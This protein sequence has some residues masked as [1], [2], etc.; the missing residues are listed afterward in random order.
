MTIVMPRKIS[1]PA[2]VTMNDGTRTNAIQ[3]PC[4]APTS[5]PNARQTATVS[6][7]DMPFVT[8][9]VA[10]IAPTTA[11]TEPTERSMSPVRMHGSMPMARMRM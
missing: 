5:R 10:E 9:I 7:T 4:H 3:K 2:S 8:I 6:G 1:M 11:S